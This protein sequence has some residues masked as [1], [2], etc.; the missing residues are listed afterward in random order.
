MI[1]NATS[2]YVQREQLAAC[3][4]ARAYTDRMQPVLSADP[5]FKDIVV[6]EFSGYGCA[7]FRGTVLEEDDLAALQRLIDH[8]APPGNITVYHSVSVGSPN[9]AATR[10]YR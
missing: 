8:S 5:R 9:P 10:G 4:A 7:R 3:A 6:Y 1:G 2:I